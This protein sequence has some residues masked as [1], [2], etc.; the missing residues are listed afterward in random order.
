VAVAWV[1]FITVLFSIPPNELAGWSILL[2]GLFMLC[3]WLLDARRRFVGPQP[4]VSDT[5][6]ADERASA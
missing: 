3:Y 6:P 5:I 1:A 2:L 4:S